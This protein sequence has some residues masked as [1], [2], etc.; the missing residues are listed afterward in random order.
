MQLLRVV[1]YCSCCHSHRP[2][3]ILQGRCEC[4]TMHF[5]AI[6]YNVMH[7]PKCDTVL[8]HANRH[9]T[10]KHI[11]I[12]W[13][14]KKKVYIYICIVKQQISMNWKC[15][16]IDK[17]FFL[18]LKSRKFPAFLASLSRCPNPLNCSSFFSPSHSLSFNSFLAHLRQSWWKLKAKVKV[19]ENKKE[20]RRMKMN[21]KKKEMNNKRTKMLVYLLAII[22]KMVK[23]IRLIL[24]SQFN[25]MILLNIYN[26]VTPFD[27]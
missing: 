17:L 23:I 14:P 27:V 20:Q 7:F 15:S 21:S 26:R 16:N 24:L 18:H 10:Y 1:C 8:I 25:S 2:W 22:L 4:V 11:L 12:N 9:N 13:S 3:A 19:D 6:S 5:W